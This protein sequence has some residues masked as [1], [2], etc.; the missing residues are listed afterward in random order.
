MIIIIINISSM[1]SSS[2]L[3]ITY[4]YLFH[5]YSSSY[6]LTIVPSQYILDDRHVFDDRY[7]FNADADDHFCRLRKTNFTLRMC[8]DFFFL[9]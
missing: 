3:F 7:V 6:L 9:S 2:S 5:L 8:I 4:S 1:I